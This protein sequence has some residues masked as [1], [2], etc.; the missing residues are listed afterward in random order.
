MVAHIR[1]AFRAH[2]EAATWMATA[3]RTE[4][5]AK[6][7]ALRIGVGYPGTWTDYS[8]LTIVRGDAF[9]NFRRADEGHSANR[10]RLVKSS[11][12]WSHPFAG[13]EFHQ[14]CRGPANFRQG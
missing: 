12:V 2:I 7:D 9:G 13:Q 5:L 14:V 4:A 10:G 11:R 1:T 8:G 6:L 3:T